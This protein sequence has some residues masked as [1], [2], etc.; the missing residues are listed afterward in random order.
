MYHP[1]YQRLNQELSRRG[2]EPEV[3]GYMLDLS[4]TRAAAI[5][6]MA[7]LYVSGETSKRSIPNIT[8]SDAECTL[9]ELFAEAFRTNVPK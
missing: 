1:D 3:A 2:P 8:F 5:R 6:D 7:Y 9:W 4:L